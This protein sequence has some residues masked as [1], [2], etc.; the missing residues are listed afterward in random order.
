M[1][2]RLEEILAFADRQRIRLEEAQAEVERL[3]KENKRLMK[4]MNDYIPEQEYIAAGMERAAVI[5]EQHEWAAWTQNDF[6]IAVE[7]GKLIAAAIRAKAK[8]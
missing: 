6:D 1:T 2:V 4:N 3:N 7:S 5:A 8:P